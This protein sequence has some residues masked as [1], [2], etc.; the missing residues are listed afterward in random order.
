M[1]NLAPK[2]FRQRLVVE[3]KCKDPITDKQIREY[4]AQLS[5]EL[6]MKTLVKPITHKS[7]K[8]GWAGWIHWETSGCHFYAWDKPTTFFSSDIY[9]CKKFDVKVAVKFTKDFFK[10]TKL[11]F[12]SF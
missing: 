6:K 1:I 4:L 5:V 9:T 12:K 8:F 10:A 2:I 7:P 11:V 3:G